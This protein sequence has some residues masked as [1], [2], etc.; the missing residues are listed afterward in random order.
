MSFAGQ[1]G[2]YT[3][4]MLGAVFFGGILPLSRQWDKALLPLLLSLSAGLM[5]GTCFL[6]LMPESFEL[7]G[8]QASAYVLAGLLFLYAF[9]KFI[10]V[11]ICEIE[12]DHCEVHKKLGTSAFIGLFLHALTDGIALGVGLLVPKLGFIVFLAIFFHKTMEAFSLTSILLHED[13]STGKIVLANAALLAAIPIGAL[14]SFWVVGGNNPQMAGIAL[15]FSAGTFLHVS[16]SDLLPEVHR[17]SHLKNQ[18][19][20]FFTLGLLLMFLLEKYLH[21]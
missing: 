7:I 12:T 10:T 6:H 18:A 14:F 1:I 4:F 16:L 17:H 2:L 8:G 21:V 5:L 19:F 11:H 3:S 15:A 9:E 13:K 20:G